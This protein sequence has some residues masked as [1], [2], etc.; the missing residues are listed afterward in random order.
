VQEIWA[1]RKPKSIEPTLV[2]EIWAR[3]EPKSIEP[4][5][6]QE[7]LG[8]KLTEE[9]ISAGN[10]SKKRDKSNDDKWLAISQKS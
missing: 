3:R 4:S 5:L 7:I 10:L 2:Q 9:H 6:V 1:R 8:K